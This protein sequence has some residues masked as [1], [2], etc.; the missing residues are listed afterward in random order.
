M[1]GRDRCYA[2]PELQQ[3]ESARGDNYVWGDPAAIDSYGRALDTAGG[4]LATIAETLGGMAVAGLSTG[5]TATA[6]T[7]PKA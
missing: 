6:F 1:S 3:W 4:A 5:P 7:A 2:L